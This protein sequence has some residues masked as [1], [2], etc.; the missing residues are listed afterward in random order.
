MKLSWSF[1]ASSL[2]CAASA[3]PAGHVYIHDPSRRP[4]PQ[5]ASTVNPETARLILAQRLGLSRFH[6]IKDPSEETLKQINAFGGRKQKLFGGENPDRTQAQV[7]VWIEGAEDAE[8]IIKHPETWS[9]FSIANPPPAS[10]NERLIQDM[11]QQAE[12]LPQKPD[13]KGNTYSS[14]SKIDVILSKL[15]PPTVYNDYL[16]VLRLD[17][18]RADK[19]QELLS[20]VLSTL[21]DLTSQ[22][23][24][25]SFGI[26]L[27]MMPPSSSHSKRTA[28]PYGSYDLPSNLHA[29][30]EPTEAPISLSTPKPAT[31]PNPAVPDLEDFPV[32]TQADGGNDTTPPLGILPRCFASKT[33]CIEATNQCSGHGEC[34]VIQKKSGGK[35]GPKDCYGCVCK[36]TFIRLNDTGMEQRRRTTHWGGPACQKK[37]ISVPFWLFVTSGVL[38]AFLISGG[39]GLLYSVGSEELP[40]VIGAG[41]SGPSRK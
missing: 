11:I 3:A 34:S 38:F 25:D 40:G 4:S 1:I 10:D 31:S 20:T 8:A 24:E 7:L 19:G 23:A 13:P 12:S 41:V 29:R 30:R 26:T 22:Y 2:Y 18:L 15:E 16:T 6:S 14:T 37:D 32:V 21:P 9:S 36:P 27:V 33:A 35:T 39:I 17:L 5:A 28:H